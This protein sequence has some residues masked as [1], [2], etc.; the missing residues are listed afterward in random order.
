MASIKYQTWD[1]A[2]YA[3]HTNAAGKP[4]PEI[5]AEL[6]TWIAAVNGNASTTADN[7][8]ALVRD[9]NSSTN[10][11]NFGFI[12]Q[13]QTSGAEVGYTGL[14]TTTGTT[15]YSWGVNT[16][17]FGGG[18]GNGGYIDASTSS[19]DYKMA[20]S[21]SFLSTVT[22][23]ADFTI[24]SSAVDGEEFFIVSYYMDSSTTYSDTW[25]MVKDIFGEW[26]VISSDGSLEEVFFYDPL[27]D[28]FY[29]SG[30]FSNY[31]NPFGSATTLSIGPLCTGSPIAGAA[32][33]VPSRTMTMAKTREVSF[34]TTS[35]TAPYSY[36]DLGGGE[37]WV[38]LNTNGLYVKFT[39]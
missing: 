33:G 12:V 36:Y 14:V 25:G 23:F 10:A 3:W 35:P 30:T 18:T 6:A 8:L 34:Q 29:K 17:T 26:M 4:L 2:N 5:T 11:N 39:P 16:A 38:A 7:S 24:A 21:H 15:I 32:V 22:T 37:Y 20:D 9:E 1:A 31:P 19:N 28:A 13:Y 27:T